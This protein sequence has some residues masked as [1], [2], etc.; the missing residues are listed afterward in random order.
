MNPLQ[1]AGDRSCSLANSSYG[2]SSFRKLNPQHWRMRQRSSLEEVDLQTLN[3]RLSKRA[4]AYGAEGKTKLLSTDVNREL[5]Q[6]F[7]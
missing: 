3:E 6:V 1:L 7:C 2:N 5:L 4:F